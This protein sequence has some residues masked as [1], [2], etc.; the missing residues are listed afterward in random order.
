MDRGFYHNKNGEIVFIGRRKPVDP[1]YQT[2]VG[3]GGVELPKKLVSHGIY[4]KKWDGEK[5]IDNPDLAVKISEDEEND[6]RKLK[7]KTEQDNSGLKSITVEQ[8]IDFIDS[9]IDSADDLPSQI[10]GIKTVLK[11]MIPFILNGG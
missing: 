7:I 4:S 6:A 3:S 9:K 1:E 8:A 10:N 2:W 5:I 11:K